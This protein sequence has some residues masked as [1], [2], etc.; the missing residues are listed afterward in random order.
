[1]LNK[2]SIVKIN[3]KDS[4]K[5]WEKCRLGDVIVIKRLR[6]LY[7]H[8]GIYV[9]NGRIIHY[10]AENNDFIGGISIHE[11]DFENFLRG[12]TTFFIQ[13]FSDDYKKFARQIG[14]SFKARGKK[15][16]RRE[17]EYY[18]YSPE[19]TVRRAKKRLG[20]THYNL[21]TNNCEHFAI[22]CKTGLDL[23][24]QVNRIGGLPLALV[25]AI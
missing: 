8:F 5:S 21:I 3:V 6:G 9:G 15:R 24:S 23:S 1:M 14:L 12:S 4:K 17:N 19:E 10:S 13:R 22:W 11:T 7:Y 25:G 20:E 2:E 18:L 16:R